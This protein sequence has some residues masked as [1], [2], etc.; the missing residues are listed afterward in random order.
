MQCACSAEATYCSISGSATG[1]AASSKLLL[2]DTC[3]IGPGGPAEHDHQ[4]HLA[5]V[6]HELQ[7][8]SC[9]KLYCCDMLHG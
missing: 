8:L 1:C 4:R 7:Y 6:P 3:G 2:V 9:G 5:G